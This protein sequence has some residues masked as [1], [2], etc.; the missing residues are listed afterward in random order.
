MHR[1]TDIY[2][3]DALEFRPECWEDGTLLRDVGYGYLP[4]NG[5]PQVC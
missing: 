3:K 5:G 2:G 1:R 4:F